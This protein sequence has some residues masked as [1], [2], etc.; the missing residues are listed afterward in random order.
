MAKRVIIAGASGLIGTALS[1]ALDTRGDEVVALVRRPSRHRGEQTW[2]PARGVLDPDV[3][4]GADAVVVLS[5]ASVGRLPWT[6]RYRAQLLDSRI[7]SVR[8]IVRALND[9]GAD[10][11]A[12]LSGSAVGY[13]GSVPGERLV[14]T[15]PLGDTFLASLCEQ[16][17]AEALTAEAVTRVALLRTAPV[18]H[19]EGVLK[20][21][22]RLTAL[23]LGG[24]LGSGTQ[25]W[26]WI[27]LEDEVQGILH[28]LDRELSGP[29]NLTGPT[30]ATAGEIGRELAR[31]MHRPFWLPAP[32]WALK[33]ALSA[34]A[35][36]SLLTC[37]A[38]VEPRV[39]L[40]T[41]YSFATPTARDAVLAALA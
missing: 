30:A 40:D 15:S 26:P 17:E 28:V 32:A 24:P 2:D 1:A 3:F 6:P 38:L 27:S 31:G 35:T 23:G 25:V 29:V 22:I 10:A 7:S 39:L 9:Y 4:E 12:L 16:W 19:R 8:T 5:G 20:P 41:G 13:Y 36:E 18:I 37:D 21:M 33:L 11:P 34:Q 14:E